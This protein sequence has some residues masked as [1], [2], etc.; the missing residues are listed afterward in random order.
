M[1][2]R[3]DKTTFGCCANPDLKSAEEWDSSSNTRIRSTESVVSVKSSTESLLHRT[4]TACSRQ[5]AVGHIIL[6]MVN[7]HVWLCHM[8]GSFILVPKGNPIPIGLCCERDA[9]SLKD[10]FL[11]FTRFLIETWHCVCAIIQYRCI[12][13]HGHILKVWF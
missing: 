6:Q 9:C 12:Y 13:T 4:A 10:T 2:N 8:H 7:T 5:L 11:L 1:K 3:K